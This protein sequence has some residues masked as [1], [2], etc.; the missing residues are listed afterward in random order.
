MAILISLPISTLATC[1]CNPTNII[2]TITSGTQPTGISMATEVIHN[3]CNMCSCDALSLYACGPG[4]HAYVYT[5]QANHE[6]PCYDQQLCV[7]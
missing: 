1:F 3:N 6:C 4:H 2:L 5:F 7:K